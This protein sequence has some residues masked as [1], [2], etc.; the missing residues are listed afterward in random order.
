M[1]DFRGIL[2]GKTS[3]ILAS[4]F[5]SEIS[6]AASQRKF[7]EIVFQMVFSHG[8]NVCDTTERGGFFLFDQIM[9]TKKMLRVAFERT[10]MIFEKIEKIDEHISKYSREY[11]FKRISSIEKSI[12]RLGIYEI[13]YD[14]QIPPKVAI[15][16][17]IRLS[18]KFGT[19]EGA[20]FVNAVLDA[21]YCK[22]DSLDGV[23]QV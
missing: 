2:K 12:L 4:L 7:R 3:V 13:L 10:K 9:V 14:Q 21:L 22:R 23:Y 8:F 11:H 16:E 5:Y 6:M 1:S 18:R 19:P 20:N 17:A 15:A